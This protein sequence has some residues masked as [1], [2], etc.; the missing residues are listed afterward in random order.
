MPF[1][2]FPPG[3][4]LGDEI[5]FRVVGPH[6]FLNLVVDDGRLPRGTFVIL[7]A[8]LGFLRAGRGGIIGCVES[9]VGIFVE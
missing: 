7:F 8:F 3:T 9:G 5:I 4:H 2:L 1:A 6:Q